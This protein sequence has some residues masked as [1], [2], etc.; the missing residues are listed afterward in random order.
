MQLLCCVLKYW[1][2]L[3]FLLLAMS[4]HRRKHCSFNPFGDEFTGY[5]TEKDQS[6]RVYFYR[7]SL[8]CENILLW[9]Y[10]WL[11]KTPPYH[12]AISFFLIS[13]HFEERYVSSFL[14]GC[15]HLCSWS[16]LSYCLLTLL[17]Q[18]FSLTIFQNM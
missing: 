4:F 3:G 17:N 13:G 10:P 9:P 18:S 15:L 1:E 12:S 5:F 2:Q 7:L 6:P 16:L 8:P 11:F 14:N